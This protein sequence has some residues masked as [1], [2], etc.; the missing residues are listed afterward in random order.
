M[1]HTFKRAMMELQEVRKQDFH[2]LCRVKINYF[3]RKRKLPLKEL[4]LSVIARK[5]KTLVME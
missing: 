3:T 1:K 4:V 2:A 5:G